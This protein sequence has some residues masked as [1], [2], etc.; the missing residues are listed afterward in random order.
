MG[1]MRFKREKAKIDKRIADAKARNK[2][3]R[4]DGDLEEDIEVIKDSDM[5]RFVSFF[6]SRLFH[7]Y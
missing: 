4:D 7:F 5:P 1:L 2:M 3:R 6:L